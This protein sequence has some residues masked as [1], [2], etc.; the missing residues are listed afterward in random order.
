MSTKDDSEN[1]KG[2]TL[3]AELPPA[4]ALP[5]QYRQSLPAEV[6][7]WLNSVEKRI[8]GLTLKRIERE[9]DELAGEDSPEAGKVYQ[10]G[11]RLFYIR[12]QQI[13]DIMFPGQGLEVGIDLGYGQSTNVLPGWAVTDAV[14][15]GDNISSISRR[16]QE[17]AGIAVS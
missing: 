15:D 16:Q 2:W 14:M 3:P 13:V 8:D 9:A 1:P 17:E 7:E 12:M 4:F 11:R 6:R 5:T 10:L